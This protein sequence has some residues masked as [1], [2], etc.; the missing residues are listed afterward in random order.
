MGAT[1]IRV[2]EISKEYMI[3]YSHTNS[4]KEL[5]MRKLFPGSQN[6]IKNRKNILALDNLSF[7][8]KKGEVL[9]IIGKNGAGKSTLLK[10]LSGITRPTS[11]KIEIFGRMTLSST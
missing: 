7:E 10:V 8:V 9:G 3:D 2:T 6:N 11:G 1:A 5:V 4:F